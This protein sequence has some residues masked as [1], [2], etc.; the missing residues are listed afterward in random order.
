[1][2]ISMWHLYHSLPYENMTPMIKE[3]SCSITCARWIVGT[4]LNETAVFVGRSSDYFFTNSNNTIVVHRH[5]MIQI[6]NVEPEEVFNE[7]CYW[8]DRF[9]EW[10]DELENCLTE[11]NGLTK[12]M[13]VSKKIFNNPMF[14]YAPDGTTL[15]ISSGYDPDVHW[16]WKEILTNGGLSESRLE[17]LKDS[18]KLTEVFKDLEPTI[19]PSAMGYGSYIHCSIL[20]KGYM[21][22]HFVLFEFC[23]KFKEGTLDLCQIMLGFFSRYMELNY[24]EYS[25]TSKF[26]QF[27]RSMFSYQQYNVDDMKL[28]LKTLRWSFKDEY[29]LFAIRERVTSAPVLLMKMYTKLL[30]AFPDTI[31]FVNGSE[32][33]LISN[34]TREHN[35]A[36]I[37]TR[38]PALLKNDYYVG[39]STVFK[40]LSDAGLYY[41]QAVNE[42]ELCEKNNSFFSFAEQHRTEYFKS[43]LAK[44][45]LSKAYLHPGLLKLYEYDQENHGEYYATMR[46]YCLANFHLSEAAS[47]LNL[48]RNSISYR[49]EKIRDIID[50]APFDQL[51]KEFDP[52]NMLTIYMTIAYLDQL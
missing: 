25:S 39:V 33:V 22:G 18:I 19:H 21:A 50:F 52:D 48:H 29:Q 30:D 14:I 3:G 43:M 1:M 42:L 16:H 5:D 34:K 6:P 13:D 4:R 51:A 8:I 11:E 24:S 20:A 26:G 23:D 47:M 46:A 7:I 9:A 36:Q 37:E 35:A 49:M 27:F 45:A 17:N 10:E 31:V 2:K 15:G 32:L 44:A 40:G 41:H 28:L 38:L 12:M